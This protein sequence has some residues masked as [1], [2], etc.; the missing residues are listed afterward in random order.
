MTSFSMDYDLP[1]REEEDTLAGEQRTY[2]FPC[3]RPY[4]NE[5]LV[6][7]R[8]EGV[9]VYDEHDTPFLD[10]FA[11]IL[12][13]SLGHCHPEVVERVREQVGV[14]GHTSTLYVTE[15][16]IQ[17]AKRLADLAPG[18]LQRSLFLN[19]GTAAIDA[20]VMVARMYTGRDEIIALRLG[21]S[22]NSVLATNL[23]AHA[24]WRPLSSAVPGIK[25]ALAPY[26]YRSPFGD[27]PE[28]NAARFADDIENI[29]Q[30]A[31]NGRPAALLAETILGVGGFIVPPPGYFQRAAEI[32]RSYGGLFICD[33]VQT[34]FGR[35]G[36]HWFGIEHWD[37][38]PDIMIMAKGIANGFPVGAVIARADVAAAWEKKMISTFGGNPVAMAAAE[39][40]LDVMVRENVPARAEARGRQLRAGLDAL[41]ERY[42]WIGEVRGMG[43]MQALELVVD[44]ESK[45]PDPER[46]QALLHAAKSE[47]LLIGLGGLNNHV[48]RIGPSLLITASEI[49]DALGRLARACERVAV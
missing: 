23:T 25:H 43:L 5:P 40:T 37:V 45:Q 19:S 38:E 18:R 20:A 13:T 12:S 27:D 6:L 24:P 47:R 35:T 22:G 16:Q 10:L 4:Y 39:T 2:L 14:L 33:E 29:I 42:P 8:A 31:T 48:I 7:K 1:F 3:V 9:W 15:Q 46:A 34:G 49:D 44:R 17:V 21:Y 30:T 28:L 26:P 11:G 41:A 32:V 36:Q